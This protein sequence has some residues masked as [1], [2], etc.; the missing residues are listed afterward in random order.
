DNLIAAE[1]YQDESI[2]VVTQR[3]TYKQ[4]KCMVLRVTIAD[5]S[6]L[7]TAMTRDDYDTK[8]Y[9][10]TKLLAK[11]K[12]SVL[13]I[14]GDFFKYNDFGYL[15]RQ[16]TLYRDRPDAE[17]DVLLIDDQSD[18][19]VVPAGDADA[20]YAKVSALEADGRKV[21]NSFNFGPIL[22]NGGEIPKINSSLYQGRYK[23]MRLAIGQLA[24]LEYAV[25]FCYGLSDATEGLSLENFAAF[26]KDSTPEVQVAY[27]L[28]GG[29]SAHVVLLQ[30]QLHNNPSGR[31]I[32]DLIYFASASDLLG[33]RAE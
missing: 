1:E 3:M 15:V 22:V 4:A 24:P 10:K 28:D 26:I 17:H 5:P 18:F 25:Y 19:Y 21:I 2:H 7:R 16:G 11:K 8:E 9:V 32:C 14:N 20:L 13:A 12:N 27:N 6:Q 31:D 33:A 30:H 29:G 23:M